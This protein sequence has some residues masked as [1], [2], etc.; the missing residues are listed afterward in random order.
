M[1]I[2]LA[3]FALFVALTGFANGGENLPMTVISG[4][5]LESGTSE[6]LTGVKVSIAGTDIFTYTD[7]YGYYELPNVPVG[8]VVLE[9][10][11][12]SFEPAR[13]EVDL[14]KTNLPVFNASLESR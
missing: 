3:T 8:P 4:S 14:Q 12:V 13:L 9:F 1:K 10:S 2:A 11:L 6:Q 7:R 5:V